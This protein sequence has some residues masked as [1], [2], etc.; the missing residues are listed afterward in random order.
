MKA[1]RRELTWRQDEQ[2][3][4]I[5]LRLLSYRP[6]HNEPHSRS[7]AFTSTPYAI[8]PQGYQFCTDEL[9]REGTVGLNAVRIALY[10]SSE[11]HLSRSVIRSD[12]AAV[13][14]PQL[15]LEH[16][17]GTARFATVRDI[18]REL[19]DNV[20]KALQMTGAANGAAVLNHLDNYVSGA[21]PF[22]FVIDDPVGVSQAERFHEDTIEEIVQQQC[23]PA[24]TASNSGLAGPYSI[25]V[26]RY[27]R[28]WAQN[29]ELGLLSSYE[30]TQSS[31]EGD[32]LQLLQSARKIVAF[33]GRMLRALCDLLPCC[34]SSHKHATRCRHQR[35][36]RHCCIPLV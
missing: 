26:T 28:T 22:T 10:V 12:A 8:D 29:A 1:L 30:R 13:L 15:E 17:A 20:E 7:E 33:T 5:L 27:P 19:R 34:T 18:I 9:I 2:R 23:C 36:K 14:L 3:A 11:R 25:S 16:S 31:S 32:L 24:A 4:A 35:G 21:V 6:A